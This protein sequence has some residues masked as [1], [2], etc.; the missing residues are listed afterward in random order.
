MI[1]PDTFFAVGREEHLEKLTGGNCAPVMV[2][3]KHSVSV[4]AAWG[5]GTEVVVGCYLGCAEGDG[6]DISHRLLA[7]WM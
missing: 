1:G 5:S 2:V 6:E 3:W 7:G 4:T